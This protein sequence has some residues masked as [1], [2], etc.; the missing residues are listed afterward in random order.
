MAT[1]QIKDGFQGGSDNQAYVDSTGHLFVTGTFSPGPGT[2]N[3]NLVQVGGAAI[4]LG[5][6]IMANSLPVTIASNQSTIPVSVSNFPATTSVT[7][8]IIPWSDNIAF[9]GGTAV[10][11]GQKVSASSIPVVLASDQSTVSITNASIGINGAT[12]PTSSTQIG[13]ENSSGNLVALLVDPSGRL[14]VDTTGSTTISGTVN[15]NINGLNAFATA[16]YVIGTAA[17]AVTIPSGT[18]SIGIKV[19]TTTPTDAV[20]VGGTSGVTNIINGTGNGY[21]LFSGD[22]VQIDVT[23]TATMYLIGTSAGQFVCLLFAGG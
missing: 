5:Q 4:T 12:A 14:L 23:P 13:A 17:T 2:G 7:Q 10:S 9:F 8:G 15:A 21:W 22:T 18:S 3:V 19:K 16:Q 1:I 20:I 11:L 6:N